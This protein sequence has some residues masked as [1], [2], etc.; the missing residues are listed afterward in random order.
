MNISISS[1]QT[2]TP[3]SESGFK[4]KQTSIVPEQTAV[5]ATLQDEYQSTGLRQTGLGGSVK[6]F[7]SKVDDAVHKIP[8]DWKTLIGAPLLIYGGYKLYNYMGWGQKS[9]AESGGSILTGKYPIIDTA[10]VQQAT[11]G[12]YTTTTPKPATTGSY[13]TTTTKPTAS[14]STPTTKPQTK[15]SYSTSTTK[16]SAPVQQ[17][18][19]NGELYT[20]PRW[21]KGSTQG[22]LSGIAKQ[23]GLSDWKYIVDANPGKTYPHTYSNGRT[24]TW[25]NAGE[26]LWIP[27]TGTVTI[28]PPV[29][30]TVQQP[31]SQYSI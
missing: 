15:P 10:P 17:A 18:T 3:E 27:K 28:A 13:K 24:D 23:Y 26:T 31:G 11:T 5:R 12:S 2:M 19:T 8:G 30:G 21:V 20:V 1:R 9:A 4:L 25:I 14:Y 16:P 6:E 22:T 29:S 7:F